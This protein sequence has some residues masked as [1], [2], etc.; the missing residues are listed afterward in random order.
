M[1]CV[2]ARG[3]LRSSRAARVPR[4]CPVIAGAAL[5][6]P[7]RATRQRAQRARVPCILRSPGHAARPHAS[8]E[9]WS[10]PV[11]SMH[12]A[13]G[14][15]H[16]HGLSG[17]SDTL[18]GAP[19]PVKAAL[20]NHAP[21]A[22]QLCPPTHAPAAASLL[23]QPADQSFTRHALRARGRQKQTRGNREE[24]P[25]LCRGASHH[26]SCVGGGRRGVCR[27][28]RRKRGCLRRLE[29]GGLQLPPV[30]HVAPAQ[31]RQHQ[32]AATRRQQRRAVS[33]AERVR[34]GVASGRSAAAATAVWAGVQGIT[35]QH[36]D[37]RNG[38]G[39]GGGRSGS[40]GDP[41]PCTHQV[42][43]LKMQA[44]RRRVDRSLAER[45]L[46]APPVAKT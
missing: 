41:A 32:P 45:V 46:R 43:Q 26:G 13:A 42:S 35:G 37:G 8:A 28:H 15:V 33:S 30:H 21:L 12:A 34:C 36:T 18:L 16:A 7:P 2:R 44:T 9:R 11:L 10:T 5:D 29:S 22:S 24:M 19:P 3:A 1:L 27:S 31:H 6:L 14:L 40:G 4:S 25:P 17:G 20:T 38:S 23:H 39:G